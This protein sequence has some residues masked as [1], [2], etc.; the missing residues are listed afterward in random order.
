MKLNTEEWK[1][2]RIGD[3]FSYDRGKES[4]P[5]QNINGDRWII[6]ETSENNGYVRKVVPTQVFNGNC[7][8]ISVNFAQ[9]VHY[10]PEPFCASVNI[11]IIRPLLEGVNKNHLLF[12]ASVLSKQHRIYSYTDKISKDLL[13][14]ELVLLPSKNGEPDWEFMEEYIKEIE[15]KYIEKI[16]EYNQE[17]IQKAL[18]VTGI[19]EDEL[20]KD[21][22]IKPA[23][24]YEEFRV[25]DLFNKKTIKGVPK[26]RENLEENKDGYHIYGQNIKYQYPQKVLLDDMY[27]Q[28][29]SR[30]IIAYTSSTA[31]IDF[32]NENFYRTGD[33]GAFQGLFPK[34]ENESLD[35]ILYILTVLKKHF[36]NFGY[37]TE[38]GNIVNL[39]ILLPAIDKETPDFEYMEKAIYIYTKKVIKSWQVDNEK[40]INALK[41]VANKK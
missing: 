33:N 12:I 23:D 18:D 19:A 2:F 14:D 10:Q 6:S 26:S 27:L 29:I 20:D 22:I 8:T 5:N 15:E 11:I 13:M 41:N 38:M 39:K 34:F 40:E 32:I 28:K 4:A 9:T 7:L 30:P 16:D 1:E 37:S 35:V 31:Q 25:G 24:I 3:W 36:A 21:L 17:N